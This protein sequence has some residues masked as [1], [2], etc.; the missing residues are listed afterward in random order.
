MCSSQQ[1]LTPDDMTKI[2]RVL[3]QAGFRKS[4]TG[5]T[6]D[7]DAAS[8]LTREFQD[9]MTNEADLALALE[10]YMLKRNLWRSASRGVE[11]DSRGRTSET[12]PK[13]S[14]RI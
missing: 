8:F 3:A 13:S 4:E 5:S 10:S 11:P 6:V 2:E 14:S 1:Y 12:K 7:Q 9:G